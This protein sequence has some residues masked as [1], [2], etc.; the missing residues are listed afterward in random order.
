MTVLRGCDFCS[1]NLLVETNELRLCAVVSELQ[2]QPSLG[3]EPRK[4][5][6]RFDLSKISFWYQEIRMRSLGKI[7]ASVLELEANVRTHNK[8]VIRSLYEYK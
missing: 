5:F 2:K 4:L 3:L 1:C 8:H 6:W 7:G